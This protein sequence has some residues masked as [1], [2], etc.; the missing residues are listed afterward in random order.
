MPPLF[1]ASLVPIVV[2]AALLAGLALRGRRPGLAAWCGATVLWALSLLLAAEP[3]TRAWGER[4]LM[5]GFFV[6]AAY[7]HAVVED[8]GWARGPLVLPYLGAAVLTV[9]G[10]LPFGLFLRNGGSE[11][12]PWFVPMFALA[13][14]ASLWPLARVFR[15]RASA[16]PGDRD[17]LTYLLAAG[18]LGTFGGGLNVLS[19]LGDQ[20]TSSGLAIVLLSL[21]L[22]AW[23]VQAA[24]LPAFG[25]FV[26]ASLR[27]SVAAALLTSLYLAL[28][29]A[30]I[31]GATALLS[32]EA[33][34]LLFL[35]VLAGQ[36][37]LFA[38]RGGLAGWLVPGGGDVGGL[39][40]ALAESEAR[41][42]HGTRL[43]AI[44][45]LASAVAHEIRN[46][47]GVITACAAVLDRAGADRG[48]VDEIRAQVDRAARFA[49]DLLAYGRPAP[50]TLRDVD[51]AAAASFAV[52]ELRMGLGVE[53]F[54]TVRVTG[55]GHAEGDMVQ[56]GR[57]VG[58]LVENAVLAGAG[59]VEVTVE[60][61]GVTVDDDG[62]GIPEALRDRLFDP[63]VTGRGRDAVRPGTGL[64]LA[65]ARSTAERH[66][67]ALIC[68]PDRGPLGGARFV[69]SLP[70]RQPLP[71]GV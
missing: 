7:H 18:F 23:V 45:S 46:P 40:A 26:E 22:T 68:T 27:Y 60:G 25:R 48:T 3:A 61:S 10:A 33:A 66:R 12:G 29:L 24:K 28:V 44:G 52:D 11:P 62:P 39:T 15:A 47:L 67:G 31:P 59:R 37:V 42:E 69:L 55:A 19:T 43:A 65:I 57:L 20:R 14:V 5:V 64:G 34:L 17:R 50:M 21:A 58:I 13:A 1:R 51:L 54:P 38:A 4:T 30:A 53:P 35:L 49:D 16:L 71:A 70:A 56:L 2:L 41:S 36:P 32:G 6:P 9:L 63:F 8:R